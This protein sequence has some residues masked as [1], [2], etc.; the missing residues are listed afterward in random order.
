MVMMK[1]SI[2]YFLSI[3]FFMMNFELVPGTAFTAAVRFR[4]LEKIG[5]NGIVGPNPLL[6]SVEYTYAM[7][8]THNFRS[9]KY[10]LNSYSI[11]H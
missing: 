1:L 10:I 5:T 6:V 9:T 4:L 3:F 7:E 11:I 2:L 8:G